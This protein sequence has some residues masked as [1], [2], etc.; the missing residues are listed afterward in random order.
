MNKTLIQSLTDSPGKNATN[1]VW[2]AFSSE[3]H[4]MRQ[5]RLAS[6]AADP[7][8]KSLMDEHDSKLPATDRTVWGS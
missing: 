3:E 2:R 5:R 8:T 1:A 4:V 6:L 7:A